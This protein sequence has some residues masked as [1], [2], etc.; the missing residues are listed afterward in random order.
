MT[1]VLR[2]LGRVSRRYRGGECLG[3]RRGPSVCGGAVQRGGWT[4]LIQRNGRSRHRERGPTAERTRIEGSQARGDEE[5]TIVI[6]IVVEEAT[7]PGRVWR[8]GVCE[9]SQR[10]QYDQQGAEKGKHWNATGHSIRRD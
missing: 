2:R 1:C 3:E 10:H 7:D 5:H 4:R 6:V 9:R 8:S